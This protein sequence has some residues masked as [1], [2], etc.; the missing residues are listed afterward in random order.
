MDPDFSRLLLG[1]NAIWQVGA[2]R[3]SSPTV[4]QFGDL[5]ATLDLRWQYVQWD[6]ANNNFVY[7]S[8]ET[9]TPLGTF[10]TN[11]PLQFLT[12]Q[13]DMPNAPNPIFIRY[14]IRQHG[15]VYGPGAPPPPQPAT[16]PGFGGGG[17][18][19]SNP[20]ILSL[21]SI[22]A[23]ALAPFTDATG[24]LKRVWAATG[25]LVQLTPPDNSGD[26]D[27][28]SANPA[29]APN[30]PLPPTSGLGRT[31]IRWVDMA[32][33]GT[34]ST[35]I[36]VAY[37]VAAN[38]RGPYFSIYGTANLQSQV[39]MTTDG[40]NSWVSIGDGLPDVPARAIAVEL[41]GPGWQDDV[42]YVGT[43]GGL[44]NGQYA[45]LFR[46]T[47]NAATSSWVWTPM[48]PTSPSGTR[49][50]LVPITD[51][52]INQ[53]F[54]TLLVATY[55]RGVWGLYI[56]VD[57]PTEI[58]VPT[59]QTTPE[60]T[61]L[62]FKPA[63]GNPITIL[64]R[65]AGLANL[66][67]QL[68][69]N[70]GRLFLA[71][72]SG[73]T[74]ESG[75][76]GTKSMIYRGS[77]S[78]INAALNGLRYVPDTDYY[79]ADEIEITVWD[80]GNTGVRPPARPPDWD[81]GPDG[82][83][84]TSDDLGW[85][86]VKKIPVRITPV[87]DAPVITAPGPQTIDMHQLLMFT[88]ANGNVISVSDVDAG[89]NPM[90]MTLNVSHGTLT[91]GSTAGIEFLDGTSN[92]SSQIKVRG[93][94]AALN[95]ALSGLRYQPNPNFPPGPP[96]VRTRSAS[97]WMTSATSARAGTKPP[98]EVSKLPSTKPTMMRRWPTSP[99]RL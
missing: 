7:D 77:Q 56:N 39:Y 34:N 65:D 86:S 47:F 70:H 73:L 83:F 32:V 35:D 54:N 17:P 1:T 11:P 69:A 76:T 18:G 41:R 20:S 15:G 72:T 31:G 93:P 84:R 30:T 87:N 80:L 23:G 75:N 62:E 89:S 82:Q 98:S 37:I 55:G 90:Q 5:E 59:A 63:N 52:Q 81:V 16:A 40:G 67:I 74:L 88:A 25:D 64:D 92:N 85:K 2:L 43:D 66:R 94:L 51:P 50:P 22:S 49:L 42:I 27:P 24:S 45:T 79:G 12:T 58:T 99:V 78:A 3:T 26:F 91:L 95:N 68:K 4:S 97:R 19:I 10:R 60:D 21:L 36:G 29:N 44:L 48:N 28:T 38:Y 71:Q 14:W 61:Q 13:A 53:Q 33:S 9:L 57:L 96:L 6:D 8:G 46:G